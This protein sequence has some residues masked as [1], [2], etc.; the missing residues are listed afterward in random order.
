MHT[1][2]LVIALVT[3]NAAPV[4]I[5]TIPGW[6]SEAECRERGGYIQNWVILRGW[7]KS[8]DWLCMA[9]PGSP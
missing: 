3:T 8:A 2:I 9:G 1:W 7:V 5:T 4:Q 6:Q